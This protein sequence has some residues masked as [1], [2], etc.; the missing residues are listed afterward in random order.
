LA[1]CE[2]LNI[3][4]MKKKELKKLSLNKKTIANLNNNEMNKLKGGFT[5]IKPHCTQN[6][7]GTSNGAHVCIGLTDIEH[8]GCNV[9]ELEY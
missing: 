2:I 3:F 5:S 1:F 8:C 7:C 4:E 9:Q 6:V